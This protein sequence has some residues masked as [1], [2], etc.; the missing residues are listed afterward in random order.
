ML[1]KAQKYVNMLRLTCKSPISNL[2]IAIK[3]LKKTNI[4][5]FLELVPLSE[6]TVPIVGR[7]DVE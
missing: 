5:K 4:W 2:L 1:R 7:L 3:S 6:S